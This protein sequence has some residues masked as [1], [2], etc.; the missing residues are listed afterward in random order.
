MYS[1]F[2]CL[3]AVTQGTDRAGGE[4]MDLHF[5]IESSFTKWVVSCGLR[6]EPFV[7]VDV[8]VQGGENPRWHLLGDYLIVHGFDA[9]EE[10]V[11]TLQRQNSG[12]SKRVYHW[13][14][15]GSED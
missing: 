3:W 7:V 8:G 9:I 6:R 5:N 4:H 11:H 1:P 14:A 15:A 2:D 12:N 13:I 10:V